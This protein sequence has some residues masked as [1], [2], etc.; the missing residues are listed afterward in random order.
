MTA[1][2]GVR[3]VMEWR[4]VM[5]KIKRCTPKIWVKSL[6]TPPKELISQSSSR[7]QACN[8]T[9]NKLFH[10]HSPKTSPRPKVIFIR[11]RKPLNDC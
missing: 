8:L 5:E 3:G 2:R 11:F 6:I 10:R 1:A 7:I 9:K 4:G